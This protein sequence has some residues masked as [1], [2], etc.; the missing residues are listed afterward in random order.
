[1]QIL[2]LRWIVLENHATIQGMFGRM[3]KLLNVSAGFKDGLVF[4]LFTF[5]AGEPCVE[6]LKQSEGRRIV[7]EWNLRDQ[8]SEEDEN[9]ESGKWT[10][11]RVEK[12]IRGIKK[13]VETKE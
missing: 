6:F 1:M 13:L 7:A 9:E 5:L 2:F 4:F 3:S 8:R 11:K 10:V 12:R